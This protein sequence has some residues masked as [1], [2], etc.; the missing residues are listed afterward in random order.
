MPPSKEAVVHASSFSR[1]LKNPQATIK[2]SSFG[3]ASF[4][5]ILDAS[6]SH[7]IISD[8]GFETLGPP[9]FISILTQGC[10]YFIGLSHDEAEIFS[11]SMFSKKFAVSPQEK[12]FVEYTWSAIHDVISRLPFDDPLSRAI[13]KI[14]RLHDEFPITGDDDHMD[15]ED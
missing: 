9:E 4:S 1:R 10:S 13:G 6:L 8:I 2:I 15:H 7:N 11:L 3:T 5:V 14:S 12:V